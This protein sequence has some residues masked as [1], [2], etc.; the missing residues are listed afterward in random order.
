MSFH[1]TRSTVAI[2]QQ[3]ILHTAID[4]N[5]RSAYYAVH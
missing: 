4:R 5:V 3:P 1:G 2:K